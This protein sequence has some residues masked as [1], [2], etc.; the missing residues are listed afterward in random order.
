MCM[1]GFITTFHREGRGD[2]IT[3]VQTAKTSNLSMDNVQYYC[4]TIYVTVWGSFCYLSGVWQ[5]FGCPPLA[6]QSMKI[7][8]LQKHKMAARGFIWPWTFF[9]QKILLLTIGGV[10]KLGLVRFEMVNYSHLLFLT[11]S[12][13]EL[14]VLGYSQ[15]TSMK[16]LGIAAGSQSL[17]HLGGR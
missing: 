9:G 5:P 4:L 7:W 15:I 17:K 3:L 1:G 10:R 14:A 6:S 12:L 8:V 2:Y 16:I 13:F 11:F